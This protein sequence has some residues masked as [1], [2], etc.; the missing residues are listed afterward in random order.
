MKLNYL[1]YN[2]FYFYFYFLDNTK[3]LRK[4]FQSRFIDDEASEDDENNYNDFEQNSTPKKKKKISTSTSIN[5]PKKLAPEIQNDS[6]LEFLQLTGF[7]T[8]A[9]E[10]D[11]CSVMVKSTP[12]FTIKLGKFDEKKIE[13]LYEVKQQ[14]EL[15]LEMFYPKISNFQKSTWFHPREMVKDFKIA[16]TP[17]RLLVGGNAVEIKG[18]S[19]SNIPFKN[20]Y[21]HMKFKFALE[22]ES[23]ENVNLFH[24][25]DS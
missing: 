19:N 12:N 6:A 23:V 4:E 1:F 7:I 15:V 8:I 14:R 22:K 25:S 17:P 11:S 10:G 18:N 21:V 2:F 20:K 9:D 3:A 24:S 13:L 5:F 16:I